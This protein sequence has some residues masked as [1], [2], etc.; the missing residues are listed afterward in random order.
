[1]KP[2]KIPERPLKIVDRRRQGSLTWIAKRYEKRGIPMS[3]KSLKK[4]MEEGYTKK[5]CSSAG[6]EYEDME[7]KVGGLTDRLI[8]GKG[9]KSFYY[10]YPK[11]LIKFISK[12]LIEDDD[13]VLVFS[14]VSS[15]TY[16]PIVKKAK[17][18]DFH[19]PRKKIRKKSPFF[20]CILSFI[21]LDTVLEVKDVNE[22]VDFLCKFIEIIRENGK[23][24]IRGVSFKRISEIP[25]AMWPGKD[26][27]EGSFMIMGIGDAFDEGFGAVSMRPSTSQTLFLPLDFL[28]KF[29]KKEGLKLKVYDFDVIWLLVA[30]KK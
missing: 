11:E 22:V 14:E 9:P 20:D 6:I 29:L 17:K 7:G 13:E 1:M 2:R 25:K 19:S 3:A 27:P 23:I 12:E 26:N 16:L 5:L 28:I 15:Q 8:S 30:E 4:R 21:E 10:P 24:I 18:T